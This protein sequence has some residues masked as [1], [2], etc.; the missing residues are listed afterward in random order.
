[1]PLAD[2]LEEQVGPLGAQ[3]QVAELVDEQQL[4]RSAVVQFFQKRVLSLGGHHAAAF[5]DENQPAFH[6]CKCAEENIVTTHKLFNHCDGR[7]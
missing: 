4:G 1:M 2:D 5:R 7:L 6:I 3:R